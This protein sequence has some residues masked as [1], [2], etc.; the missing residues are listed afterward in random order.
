MLV[1][2]AEIHQPAPDFL[3]ALSRDDD[4]PCAHGSAI[5]PLAVK[6]FRIPTRPLCSLTHDRSSPRS[7]RKRE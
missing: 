4:T 5:P 7:R 2:Q 6:D 1:Q 3:P